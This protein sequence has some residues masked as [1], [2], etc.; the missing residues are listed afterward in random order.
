ML[1]VLLIFKLKIMKRGSYIIFMITM[2]IMD[3]CCFLAWIDIAYNY[4][5]DNLNTWFMDAYPDKTDFFITYIFWAGFTVC[6]YYI[7]ILR[8]LEL[9]NAVHTAQKIIDAEV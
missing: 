6:I 5:E 2:I 9:S 7:H 4:F 8:E 3:L 1:I